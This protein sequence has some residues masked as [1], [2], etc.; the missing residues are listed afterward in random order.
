MCSLAAGSAVFTEPVTTATSAF[1]FLQT[2]R[3]TQMPLLSMLLSAVDQRTRA[4]LPCPCECSRFKESGATLYH[5]AVL[6]EVWLTAHS[7]HSLGFLCQ[8][9]TS[10]VYFLC[11]LSLFPHRYFFKHPE[12]IKKKGWSRLCW[13]ILT[14]AS[15]SLPLSGIFVPPWRILPIDIAFNPQVS[16]WLAERTF[17]LYPNQKKPSINFKLSSPFNGHCLW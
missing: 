3:G 17:P 11:F 6:Q 8:V 9:T 14:T 5:C 1:F 10:C 15:L 16:F 7:Q 13:G 2:V 12:K 4:A